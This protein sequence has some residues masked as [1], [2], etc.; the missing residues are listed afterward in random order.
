MHALG[1]HGV[2]GNAALGHLAGALARKFEHRVGQVDAGDARTFG[3]AREREPGA[4]ADLEDGRGGEGGNRLGQPAPPGFEHGAE[5]PVVERRV[6]A[7]GAGHIAGG[8]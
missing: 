5:E 2:Q 7:V 6:A 8:G 1:V 4:D 3:V